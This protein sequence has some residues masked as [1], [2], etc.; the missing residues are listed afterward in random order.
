MIKDLGVTEEQFA[1]AVEI[2][3]QKEENRKIIDRLLSVD[4]FLQ[5]KK[6]MQ[7]RKDYGM[8]VIVLNL[9]LPTH[10]N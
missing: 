5:F 1:K 2:A 4:D 6:L 10:L 9:N 7:K 3:N 8:N